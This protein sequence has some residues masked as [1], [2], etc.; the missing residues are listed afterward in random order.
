MLLVL[1]PFIRSV[2]TI[3]TKTMSFR[4]CPYLKA[5]RPSSS[6][7]SSSPDS[8]ESNLRRPGGM[9]MF[10]K[11]VVR[12]AHHHEQ[13]RRVAIN[14]RASWFGR[15]TMTV[16]ILEPSRAHDITALTPL[17]TTPVRSYSVPDTT[18]F[19]SASNTLPPLNAALLPQW[20]SDVPYGALSDHKASAKG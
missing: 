13:S 10:Q 4:M 8:S 5:L 20:L 9:R 1:Q 3:L 7:C 11:R 15:L 18:A 16:R 14:L 19:S 6:Y 17:S 2:T 12:Q